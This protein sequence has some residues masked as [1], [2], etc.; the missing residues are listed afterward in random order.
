MFQTFNFLYSFFNQTAVYVP[1]FQF[2]I[3]RAVDIFHCF[4]RAV[5]IQA[6]VHFGLKLAYARNDIFL[7]FEQFPFFLTSA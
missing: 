7:N 6:V 4:C 1:D 5:T 3:F 2:F